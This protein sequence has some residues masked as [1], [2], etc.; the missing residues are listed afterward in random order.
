M[1][2]TWGYLDFF[3]EGDRK[4]RKSFRTNEVYVIMFLIT[5]LRRGKNGLRREIVDSDNSE[6][7]LEGCDYKLGVGGSPGGQDLGSKLGEKMGIIA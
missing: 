6:L 5:F 3:L 4:A 2:S 1:I 7:Q